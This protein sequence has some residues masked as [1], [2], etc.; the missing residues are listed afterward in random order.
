MSGSAKSKETVNAKKMDVKRTAPSP[1]A[2]KNLVLAKK[3]FSPSKP[4]SPHIN[5]FVCGLTNGVMIMRTE[6][7]NKKNVEGFLQPLKNKCME[8]VE[9]ASSLDIVKVN[10]VF[11][12]FYF[13]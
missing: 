12:I 11:K 4:T 8:D 3:C 1:P 7:S 2:K 13:F 10:I 5:V 9:F 6:K